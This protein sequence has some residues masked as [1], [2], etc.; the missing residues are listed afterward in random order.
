MSPSD[1]SRYRASLLSNDVHERRAGSRALAELAARQHAEFLRLCHYLMDDHELRVRAAI[2][3]QLARHGD[4][5]DVV[6][7][8]SARAALALPEL[9][10]RALLALETVGTR[11][12]VPELYDLSV[13]GEG[14]ALVALAR[15]VR[16]E[17]Q[18]EQALRVSR[19]WLMSDVY[20]QRDEALRALGI[21]STAPREEDLRRP[22]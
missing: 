2:Y 9:R 1:I 20:Y 10:A 21:L 12:V 5:D 6:A 11:A 13:A 15:Q 7:E 18:R 14:C 17:T 8:M 19:E 3:W 16:T 4:R 22:F